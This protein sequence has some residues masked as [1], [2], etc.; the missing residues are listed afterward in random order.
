MHEPLEALRKWDIA[1]WIQHERDRFLLWVPVAF[2]AGILTYFLLPTEPEPVWPAA[3]GAVG[4]MVTWFGRTRG[5]VPFLGIGAILFSVGWG[6]SQISTALASAPV[7]SSE[8]RAI[9]IDGR[10]IDVEPREGDAARVVLDRVVIEDMSTPETPDRVRITLRATDNPLIVGARLTARAVLRPPPPPV[11][12]GGYDFQRQAYFQRIGA[13]GFA[14]GS[15]NLEVED[16]GP[17]FSDLA[18]ERVRRAISD[19][20]SAALDGRVAGLANAL[21][22][23]ERGAIAESDR[24]AMRDAGLAHL[25]AISGLHIGIV[26]GFIFWGVRALLAMI[27]S[28]ATR[29]P[30]KKWAA[31]A[32]MLFALTY[33]LIAGATPPTQ[34][35][36]LMVAIALTAV[37]I[38]RSPISMRL[39]AFAALGVM[40]LSPVSVLGPS[41][42]LSFA[43]VV[44]LIAAFEWV[45]ARRAL[46]A[47]LGSP[48]GGTKRSR[49]LVYLAATAYST[50]IATLATAPFALFHFQQAALYGIAANLV[51]IPLM[52]F[53]IMPWLALGCIGALVGL[54]SLGF[55]PA[56]WGIAVLREVAA[57]IAVWPGAVVQAPMADNWTIALVAAGGLW[58][59]LW[60]SRMRWA[61]LFPAVAGLVGMMIASWPD[62]V[63]SGTGYPF[64]VAANNRL[65]VTSLTRDKFITQSWARMAG[66][67]RTEGLASVEALLSSNVGPLACDGHGCVL[68]LEENTIALSAS[69]DALD[70]DCQRADLVI[71]L[72]PGG[73][74]C[75]DQTVLI[76]YWDLVRLGAHAI[77]VDSDNDLRVNS[78]GAVRGDRPWVSTNR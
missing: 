8:T 77:S 63:V 46:I 41:F 16:D 49:P 21:V 67:D 39:V 3:I 12:P 4:V 71:H 59:C 36:F 5:V 68:G 24:D 35:A 72:F 29:F 10:I 27:P 54:G 78:V 34:R 74:P 20:I 57:E 60:R 6:W 70:A 66:L 2:G 23:G 28:L 7:L 22:I 9:Q 58:L 31:L 62:L 18:V 50:L 30:I 45:E 47:G 15:A 13:V 17:G 37:M 51:A 25:L 14:L 42:Q 40:L 1:Q 61:G 11:A 73:P 38:D 32:A 19:D 55:V 43:A 64:G 52:A 48:M 75:S 56:G 69:L 65:Y 33:M 76:R 53:W 26:A 44:A